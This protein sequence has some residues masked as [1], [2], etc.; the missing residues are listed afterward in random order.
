MKVIIAGGGIGGLRL[1]A[2]LERN[3]HDVTVY[4]KQ[5]GAEEMRYDWHDDVNPRALVSAGLNIPEGSFPKSNWTFIGPNGES[6]KRLIQTYEN[7]DWSVERKAI[8]RELFSLLKDTKVV[9]NATVSKLITENDKVVGA[10]IANRLGQRERV[11]CDLVV[12]SSGVRSALRDSLC[13]NLE[14]PKTAPTDVFFAYRAFYERTDAP[15]PK[16]TNKVYMKHI[17]EQGISWCIYDEP[18][19]SVNVLI[20][21]VGGL[22]KETLKNAL[23]DLRA[24]NPILGNKVL[25]GGIVAE[26]PVRRPLS[27]FACDGYVLIGDSACMTVPMIGSGI[28]TSLKAAEILADVI[29]KEKVNTEEKLFEYQARVFKEFGALHCYVEIIKNWMLRQKDET[30]DWFFSSG[31]VNNKDMCSMAVGKKMRL[32]LKDCLIKGWIGLDYP[33]VL[34]GML[35]MLSKAN[36]AYAKAY[37]IPQVYDK[38]KVDAWRKKADG[39]FKYL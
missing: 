30:V 20:G 4:E 10:E 1:A 22:S 27:R 19:D 37:A 38:K 6:K 28:A 15:V 25:R 13:G 18:S 26:I 16:E 35:K 11:F 24:R 5:T 8:N 17:G 23:D 36:E 14:F 3:G 34:A 2:Y 9:F 33:K 39:V 29:G 12:D 7:I 31:I 21:R 32:T